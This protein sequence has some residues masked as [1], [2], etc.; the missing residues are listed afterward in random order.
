MGG[1]ALDRTLDE[2]WSPLAGTGIDDRE[3]RLETRFRDKYDV[4]GVCRFEEPDAPDI[5]VTP[6]N[7]ALPTCR[8]CLSD[9]EQIL[10]AGNIEIPSAVRARRRQGAFRMSHSGRHESY[11]DRYGPPQL[12]QRD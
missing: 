10:A 6:S 8:S 5:A 7:V 3:E 1:W 12:W 2:V 9:W 4:R 11:L